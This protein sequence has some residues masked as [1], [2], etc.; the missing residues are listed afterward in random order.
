MNIIGESNH[1]A[2]MVNKDLE[3]GRSAPVFPA[4]SVQAEQL[5]REDLCQS[6]DMKLCQSEDMKLI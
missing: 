2:R 1:R 5:A 4:L 6:E 3:T